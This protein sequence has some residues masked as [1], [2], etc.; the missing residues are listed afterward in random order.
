MDETITEGQEPHTTPE[1]ESEP[2]TDTQLSDEEIADLRKKA[3][4]SSQNFERLKKAE[5]ELK[6]LKGQQTEK[7]ESTQ[8]DSSL[9]PKDLYALNRANVDLEDIDEVEK[10]A[11]ILGKSI[12]E[13]L[14]DDMVKS[15]LQR[16]GEERK[17]AEASNV[18]GG[19]PSTKKASPQEILK[20]AESGNIPEAGTP[21]AE[22]LFWARRGGRRE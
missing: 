16:R 22:E 13:A 15:L 18:R 2:S 7:K 21:E 4:A 14:E 8:T 19:K 5:E 11:K 10:A 12:P 3:A 9:S 17:T 6:K 1:G 20:R